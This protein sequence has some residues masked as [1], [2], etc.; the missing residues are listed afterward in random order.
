MLC[1]GEEMTRQVEDITRRK[2]ELLLQAASIREKVKNF[3]ADNAGMLSE[4]G[5]VSGVGHYWVWCN[6]VENCNTELVLALETG[7]HTEMVDSF[8]SLNEINTSLK[9]SKVL[10]L[11]QVTCSINRINFFSARISKIMF[12]QQQNIGDVQ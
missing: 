2:E 5:I 12:L 10:V 7:T 11:A 1:T 3:G 8:N 4:L 6:L 9:E